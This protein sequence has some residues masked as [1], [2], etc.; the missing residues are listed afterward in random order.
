MASIDQDI[1]ETYFTL[2]LNEDA[3]RCCKHA[4]GSEVIFLP[5]SLNIVLQIKIPEEMLYST[6]G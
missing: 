5:L 6:T 3:K 2:M 4:G 1:H